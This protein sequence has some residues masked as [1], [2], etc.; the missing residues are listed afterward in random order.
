MSIQTAHVLAARLALIDQLR[1]VEHRLA[2]TA[3]AT[4]ALELLRGQIHTLGNSIQIIDL[5]SAELQRR[6]K[7]DPDDMLKDIRD[8]AL[9]ARGVLAEMIALAQPATRR[10]RGAEFAATIRNAVELVRPA[11]GI[12]ID[13]RDEMLCSTATSRLDAFE[14]E[15]IVISVLLDAHAATTLE[16]VLR[17]RVID[18]MPWLELIRCDDRATELVLEPPSLLG[19][20]DQLARIGGGELSLTPGRHGHELVVALPRSSSVA[21]QSSSS[22]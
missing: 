6:S 18:E 1:A 15:T 11:L 10:T 16:L 4:M 22:S 8:A 14:L 19:I 2:R 5:T 3:Q 13:V 7:D 12:A 20:V 9:A 21:A 17:E